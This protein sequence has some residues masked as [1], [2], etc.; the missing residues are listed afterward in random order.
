MDLL[1]DVVQY[2]PD[3]P[4]EVIFNDISRVRFEFSHILLLDSES[5]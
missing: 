1:H 2:Y 4:L 5:M 3:G